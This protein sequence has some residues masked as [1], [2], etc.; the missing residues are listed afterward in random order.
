MHD[1]FK[2]EVIL[3]KIAQVSPRYHPDIGGIETYVKEIS[4]RLVRQGHEVE[5]VTTDPS[6]KL[7]KHEIMNGV[8]ITRFRSLAPNNAFFFTP[9]IYF[10]LKKR[11]Y[12]VIHAHNY[13][14][15]PS[16]FA[17]LAKNDAQ[18]VFNP[19]FHGKGHTFFRNIL[20]VPYKLLGHYIFNKSDKIICISKY[21]QKKV[22]K[23]FNIEEGSV[24]ILPPGLD[25]SEFENIEPYQK[26]GKTILYVGRLE[27]YKGVQY[28]IEALLRLKEYGLVIIGEGPYEKNLKTL[29]QKSNSDRINWL[30]NISRED[31]LR[32]YKS[33]DVFVILS[34]HES[35]GI[36]VA[37]AL[38]SGTPCVVA[39]GSAL[40]EFV[41][42][43]L[44]V[45][46]EQP[47]TVDKLVDAV[48][49]LDN[50]MDKSAVISPKIEDWDSVVERLICIYEE[51]DADNCLHSFNGE[52]ACASK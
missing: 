29:S 26:K 52:Y 17:A 9:N 48:I 7:K 24:K 33:A 6:G 42:G 14:A 37:E 5:V 2:D 10:F 51:L 3:L 40:D 45:G 19:Y 36:S 18:L 41:D 21:E 16:L 49:R 46:I 44:C 22:Q 30:K 20:H 31:L 50:L 23:A 39:L 11:N 4:E 12:D 34:K 1:L 32:Y 13:H 35:Y 43:R 25:M 15:F 28:I 38:A 8:K 47:I 27:A